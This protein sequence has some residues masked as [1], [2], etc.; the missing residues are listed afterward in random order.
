MTILQ[1]KWCHNATEACQC[2]VQDHQGTPSQTL[3]G[4]SELGRKVEGVDGSGV[5]EVVLKVLQGS[6]AGHNG[7]D[8]ESKH[9]EHSLQSN[10][11]G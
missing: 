3:V 7:L 5:A 8:K 1:P 10:T 2:S 6:L 4:G 11:Q 9:G